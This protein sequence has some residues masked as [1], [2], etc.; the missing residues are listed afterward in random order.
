MSLWKKIERAIDSY[1][2]KRIY[3][4]PDALVDIEFY[5]RSNQGKLLWI[6]PICQEVEL[7]AGTEF[8]ITTHERNFRFEYNREGLMIMYLQYT[9]GC[10][11][12]KR[13]SSEEIRNPYA[14]ELLLD[15]SDIN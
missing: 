8:K 15:F 10:K 2:L 1:C 5:N 4:N 12:Y 11:L 6:E 9:F 7:K 14:W 3:R 13:A